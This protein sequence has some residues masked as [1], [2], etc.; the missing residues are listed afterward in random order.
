MDI[1]AAFDTIN[2]NKVLQVISDLLDED[3][4]Y[5]LV[6][7]SLLLPP[8]SQASQGSSRRLFK[9]RAMVDGTSG[10]GSR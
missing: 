1:R 8:A 5:L 9:T 2:Q 7:Y 10:S 4:D 6:L 3:Y